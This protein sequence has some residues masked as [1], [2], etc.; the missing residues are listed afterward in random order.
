[1]HPEPSAASDDGSDVGM[2]DVPAGAAAPEREPEPRR[3]RDD[4]Y[5]YDDDFIDDAELVE[6]EPVEDEGEPYDESADEDFKPEEEEEGQAQEDPG[7][8]KPRAPPPAH[9]GF[10]RFFVN[11][12][13]IPN[14]AQL[15]PLPNPPDSIGNVAVNIPGVQ[16]PTPP[17]ALPVKEAVPAAKPAE[18]ALKPAG[19]EPVKKPASPGSAASTGAPG[20]SPQA[21]KKKVVDSGASAKSSKVMPT[22]VVAEIA[23]LEQLC[24]DEFG[25]KKPKMGDAKVQDQL[26]VFFRE[27]LKS[28]VAR[29]FSDIAK[30]RRVVA[31]NDEVWIRLSKFIRTKRATI[32]TLGHAL[33]WRNKEIE[34]KGRVTVTEGRVDALLEKQRETWPARTAG[35]QQPPDHPV[36]WSRELDERLFDWYRARSDLQ[37]AKN[38]LG[39]RVRSI[40]KSVPTWVNALKNRAFAGFAVGEQ[41]VIDSFRRIEEERAALER[42]KREAERA[43]RKRK[44]EEQ[45]AAIAAKKAAITNSK[46]APTPVPVPAASAADAPQTAT[47]VVP[48][49]KNTVKS[50][51]A[52]KNGAPVKTGA[53]VKNGGSVKNGTGVKTGG[54]TKNGGGGKNGSSGK[55]VLSKSSGGKSPSGKTAA[56]KSAQSKGGQAKTTPTKTTAGKTASAKSTPGT[57]G[58]K[59]TPVKAA[60][61]KQGKTGGAASQVGSSPG[62][63]KQTK[64]TSLLKKNAKTEGGPTTAAKP[65]VSAAARKT[66]AAAT[67]VAAAKPAQKARPPDKPVAAAPLASGATPVQPGGAAATSGSGGQRQA[68]SDDVA[69]SGS[70]SNK[71]FEVIE[72]D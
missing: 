49:P 58:A 18:G 66:D 42:Q 30:D 39:A 72:L 56:V 65:A 64:L 50:G 4:E 63:Q 2:E 11:R 71:T 44:K 46:G 34:A 15:A 40:K 32:E 57:P 20:A 55:T 36:G 12:G 61:A 6:E 5:D 35:E 28:G 3:L 67:G 43:E 9:H 54:V 69:K 8:G 1:M 51:G 48:R 14:K 59:T 13:D 27:A 16:A 47:Q 52:I 70:G 45:A 41:E 31:L 19:G 33:H 21:V 26:S 23:K 17:P 22:A 25:D 10:G 62:A 37:N 68:V 24:R 29:L 7:K 60:T 38:Q 53:P